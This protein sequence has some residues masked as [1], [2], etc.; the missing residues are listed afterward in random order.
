MNKKRY[1]IAIICIFL[2]VS[3]PLVFAVEQLPTPGTQTIPTASSQ[4]DPFYGGNLGGYVYNTPYQQEVRERTGFNNFGPE[5][6]LGEAII[7]NVKD[8]EPKQVRQSLLEQQDVPV[9]VYLRGTTTGNVFSF[10]GGEPSAQDPLTGISNTPGIES[11]IITPNLTTLNSKFVRSVNWIRPTTGVSLSNL[12]YLVIYLKKLENENMT[13]PDNNVVVDLNSRIYLKLQDAG[14]FGISEQDVNLEQYL[15]EV[16]F[17]KNKDK[18]SFFSGR[19]YVRAVK[20]SSDS[21]TLQVYNK[22]LFPI[23]LYTPNPTSPATTGLTPRTTITLSKNNQLSG[24]ISFGYTGNPLN[25]LF[26]IRLEGIAVPGEKA[27]IEYRV[28]GKTINRKIAVGNKLYPSSD[29]RVKSAKVTDKQLVN[30]KDPQII[31]DLTKEFNLN[32]QQVKFIENL[33]TQAINVYTAVHVVELEN[34]ISSQVKT[35]KRKVIIYDEGNGLKYSYKIITSTSAGFLENKYCNGGVG[36]NV[37]SGDLA[38]EAVKKYKQLITDYPNSEQAKKSKRDL[39]DIYEQELI[40]FVPCTKVQDAKKKSLTPNPSDKTACDEFQS[41]MKEL[42]LYYGSLVGDEAEE[43]GGLGAIGGDDYLDDEAISIKLKRVISAGDD[44]PSIDLKIKDGFNNQV[45]TYRLGDFLNEWNVIDDKEKGKNF[46]WKIENVLSSSITLRLYEE[47]KKGNITEYKSKGTQKTLKLNDLDSLQIDFPEKDKDGQYKRTPNSISIQLSNINIKNEA[48][49]TVIP[50]AGRAYTTSSF[51]VHIPIDPRPFKWTP[52]ELQSQIDST[53]KIISDL[54]G[55]I[56][57][58]DSY[59]STLKKICLGV[60]AVL[61]IKNS[62]TG[63]RNI[64]RVGVADHFKLKCKNEIGQGQTKDH[65]KFG[66][67]DEC[68]NHYSSE[69]KSFTDKTERYMDEI[70]NKIKGKTADDLENVNLA[71]SDEEKICGNFKKFKAASLG[72]NQE[73][74]VKQY[75]D[76]LLNAKVQGDNSLNKEYR[77]FYNKSSNEAGILGRIDDYNY[78]KDYASKPGSKWNASDEKDLQKI[79]LKERSIRNKKNPNDVVVQEIKIDPNHNKPGDW[80]GNVLGESGNPA[81]PL[82]NIDVK[83]MSQ[84]HEILRKNGDLNKAHQEICEK[85]IKGGFSGGKCVDKLGNDILP[86][87]IGQ[88]KKEPVYEKGNQVFVDQRY[89]S[90]L[91]SNPSVITAMNTPASKL[92]C[93][94]IGGEMSNPGPSINY[95]VPKFYYSTSF[96]DATGRTINNAYAYGAKLYA[97]YGDDGLPYCYPT[98]K[99]EYAIVRE[100]YKGTGAISKVVVMNVGSNGLVECGGGDDE[101]AT[102]GDD[103]VP[104]ASSEKKKQAMSIGNRLKK[105]TK[106]QPGTARQDERVGT[107]DGGISISCD[108]K[109][110]EVLDSLIQPKCIDVMDPQDCKIMFNFCDP[111]MCPSSRCNLGGRVAPRNVIQSGLIGSV[112]LCAPN[113]KQGVAVPVC[114]TGISAGLKAIKSVLEGYASCL[115]INLKQGKNVG[116]CDYIRSVGICEVVWKEAYSLLSISGGVVDWA[117]N[118]LGG[119]PQGGGEYLRFQSSLENVGNSVKVFTEEYKTTYTAQ[120]LS[121]STEEIGSQ[122]CRLSVNGKLPS[123]GKILDQLTEP[124]NPP[125]FT[126]FFS[127]DI[128]ASPGSSAG[129]VTAPI[130]TEELSLYNVFY[131]IYAGTGNFQGVYSQPQTLFSEGGQQGI[132]QPIVYSV[133]LVNQ[134][135]GYPALYVTNPGD[136]SQTVSRIDAGKFSQQAVQKVGKKGYNQICVDINGVRQCGFGR[137]STSFALNELKDVVTKQEAGKTISS[138]AEC[139]SDPQQSQDYSAAKLGA[140]GVSQAAYGAGPGNLLTPQVGA[141]GTGALTSGIIETNLFSRGIVR[142]CSVNEPTQEIGRW[143]SVGSCRKDKTGKDRGDCWLDVKSVKIDDLNINNE[144][145]EKLKKKASTGII[146]PSTGKIILQSLNDKRDQILQS[147]RSIVNKA[148]GKK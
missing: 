94:N 86:H 110:V 56:T 89:Y 4:S 80:G 91:E 65:P 146:D 5:Q 61:T 133:Y 35:L 6:Y 111:V 138:A 131:H 31:I 60:F 46:T 39:K 19:G 121:Q 95:C 53:R 47:I 23:S 126:A 55:I 75:R 84:Y 127:E 144:L 82:K 50:G 57:K 98:N 76:C 122:I 108:L 59:I 48:Y 148:K 78:A 15:D 71:T 128:Y 8:Y 36:A 92:A 33:G 11:L 100:R 67:I 37:L 41:D 2:I 14:L 123:V 9:F 107:V 74:V 145:K 32:S 7:V 137:V 115:E 16:E 135:R 1:V 63:T 44:R 99:G 49:I 87:Q 66:N 106:N 68:L 120:F 40:E 139:T 134:E 118:K 85:E 52:D 124:E 141:L 42:A 140:L 77:E 13:P 22:N 102:G 109:S 21:V 29:W 101:Y 103:T 12:G 116:F 38:C 114:L 117:V 10:L 132:Q 119:A 17:M 25:D 105:C 34:Q 113:F 69:I 51:K 72:M 30:P 93:E 81:D 112:L 130:G 125:Q 96:T 90:Q 18:Y 24:P 136:F 88:L 28:S 79:M 20:I 143:S 26:Q 27:E 58:L 62:F 54:D 45:K 142:V 97:R 73:D 147:I 3:M 104:E 70:N 43:F 64:A 83:G 129:V